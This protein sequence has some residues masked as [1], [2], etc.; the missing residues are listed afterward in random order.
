MGPL[1]RLAVLGTFPPEGGRY[2]AS[3]S[4]TRLRVKDSENLFSGDFTSPENTT[5]RATGRD[6]G[7]IETIR[8]PCA[9]PTSP[10][11]WVVQHT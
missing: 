4:F 8:R 11:Y 6:T 9:A 5:T 10:T 3:Q 7:S 2:S 1:I